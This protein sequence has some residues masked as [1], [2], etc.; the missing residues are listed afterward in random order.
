ML[1]RDDIRSH[2]VGDVVF[3][4]ARWPCFVHTVE[5]PDGL[6]LVD[7]GMIDSTPALDAEWAPRPA[8]LADEVVRRVAVVVNTHLHFDHCGGNRLFAGVPIHVQRREL[9]DAR[10][11]PDYTIR[12]WVDFPGAAYVEHE[13]EAEILPGLRLLP[14]PGHTAGHQ[15]VV[16]DTDEG[17][18]VL[19]GDVAYSFEEL[20]RGDTEGRRLVLELGAL[21]WLAHVERPRV[22][23][24]RRQG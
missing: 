9:A 14:A 20:E 23:R 8:P 1:H 13:G 4:G 22:P 5:H 3:D 15:V 12:E 2:L 21:T 24:L 10:T 17:P 11:Q 18:V 7:T 6:V 16:V 19:G